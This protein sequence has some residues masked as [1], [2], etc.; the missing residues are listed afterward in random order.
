MYGES[1][2]CSC[3]KTK[4]LPNLKHLLKILLMIQAISNLTTN[5]YTQ[6]LLTSSNRLGEASIFKNFLFHGTSFGIVFPTNSVPNRIKPL[7]F[8]IMLSWDLW[9]SSSCPKNCF[10]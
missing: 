5:Y 9:D 7:R 10:S 4:G 8:G 3:L 6:K 2:L 1:S